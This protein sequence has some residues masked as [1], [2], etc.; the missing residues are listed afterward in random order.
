MTP[1]GSTVRG[2]HDS[3]TGAKCMPQAHEIAG[4]VLAAWRDTGW[5]DLR[6]AILEHPLLTQDKSVLLNLVQVELRQLF[7][8]GDSISPEAY[9]GRFPDL[10]QD[11]LRSIH[12]CVE[13]EFLVAK[14]P[15]I[16]SV[17]TDIT[18]PTEG[19]IF[20]GFQL[21]EELGRGASSRVFRCRQPSLGDREVVLK[22]SQ[23]AT[24]EASTL[25][26]LNHP[27]VVPV[28][29]TGVNLQTMLGWI[30]MPFL[31]RTTLRDTH[32]DGPTQRRDWS[33]GPDR[34]YP[35]AWYRSSYERFE[36][37]MLRL[38]HEIAEALAYLHAAGVLH[39]DLKPSNVLL[40]EEDRALLIDFNLSRSVTT[41]AG[42]VG[43][44]LPYMAPEQ[45][46][47]IAS[48]EGGGRCQVTVAS[49][50]FSFGAMLLEVLSGEPPFKADITGRDLPGAA[51]AILDSQDER[52]EFPINRPL[53]PR[54]A[55][56]IDS[57]LAKR[58][59]DRP[60][61]FREI[62]EAISRLRKPS[63]R[64]GRYTRRHP[65]VVLGVLAV[66]A[67]VLSAS[68]L[69]APKYFESR[70]LGLAREHI[71]AER[72]ELAEPLIVEYLEGQP[73]DNSARLLLASSQLQGGRI[74]AAGETYLT[75]W[76]TS[77]DGRLAAMAGYCRN[78]IGKHAQAEA[79]YR[80]A[81][82]HGYSSPAID[83]NL[84]AGFVF[85]ISQ[86]FDDDISSLAEQ[87]LL[88]VYK[89]L[90]DNETVRITMLRHYQTTAQSPHRSRPCYPIEIATLP[91]PDASVAF[92]S[93]AIQFLVD[94][95]VGDDE[96]RD[97]AKP[98]LARL[99]EV[100]DS[101]E[102]SSILPAISTVKLQ[103]LGM[104]PEAIGFRDRRG[105]KSPPQFLDPRDFSEDSL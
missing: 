102:L 55:E 10:P 19:Q 2:E 104:P 25:G 51:Q 76:R 35:G 65:L 70:S 41:E 79:L 15:D 47:A 16:F 98:C 33:S 9:C 105:F 68:V 103:K 13:V 58:P 43:G 21:I 85:K 36:N 37:R 8:Q 69:T 97:R 22:V 60:G 5:T 71:A 44:T 54:V 23:G 80:E 82:S 66:F 4:L 39:G 53:D 61:D 28:H 6:T 83:H 17:L 52:A 27:S 94:Y 45:L 24:H 46:E 3:T 101:G 11:L 1:D 73:S 50:A 86:N 92:C 96:L 72:Y 59:Q 84:A 7:A 31:G 48:Q 90:P 49:E 74:R 20:E 100:V 30:C 95:G 89:S 99:A 29:A 18:W 26:K 42:L 93:S 56:L 67:S 77:P 32:V 63:R 14:A 88:S 40:S 78:L 12:H 64:L 81:G 87:L 91:S 62:T 57:L 34:L 75:A 38:F